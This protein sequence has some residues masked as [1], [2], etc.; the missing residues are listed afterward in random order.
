MSESHTNIINQDVRLEY[1]LINYA[2]GV[3]RKAVVPY[4]FQDGTHVAPGDWVCLPALAM[5][6]D[7]QYYSNPD[8]FDGTRFLSREADAEGETAK[9][10]NKAFTDIDRAFPFWG[11]GKHA[12]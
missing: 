8:H 1:V 7:A 2:V 5:Q 3:R 10:G 11:M 9:L 4:T 6:R 12:W